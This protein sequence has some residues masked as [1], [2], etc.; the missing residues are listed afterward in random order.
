ME[1]IKPLGLLGAGVP[2][3]LEQ[4]NI[5]PAVASAVTVITLV[6]V[7]GIFSFLWLSSLFLV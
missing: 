3:L 2:C 1:L 4:M 7:I 6:D 5:E